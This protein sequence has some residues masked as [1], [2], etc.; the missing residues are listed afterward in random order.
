MKILTEATYVITLYIGGDVQD[1][2]RLMREFCYGTPLCVTITPTTF[3]YMGGAEEGVAIG[4]V[5]Y[6]RFPTSPGALLEVAERVAER[7]IDEM[8]QH[9]ALLVAPDATKWFSR[10]EG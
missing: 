6:P 5:N 9:S 10:R 8:H 7:L 3:V 1:A 2:R 4:F